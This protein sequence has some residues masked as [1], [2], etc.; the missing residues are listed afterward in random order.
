MLLGG[1]RRTTLIFALLLS[2]ALT[3]NAVLRPQLDW[4][5]LAYA[6]CVEELHGGDAHAIH[7][8][9][10]GAL[11]A[12]ASPEDA[13]RLRGEADCDPDTAHY[14]QRMADDP[15]AFHA[16]LPFYRGRV[17]YIALLALAGAI[18][19][20]ALDAALL[21]AL[22]SGLAFTAILL[23]WTTR[24]LPHGVALPA[25]LVGVWLAAVPQ[26][27][28]MSTPDMLAAALL[29]GGAY[30]LAETPRRA[31]G[32]A[33]LCLAVATRANHAILAAALVV[34]STPARPFG[35]RLP[36]RVVGTPLAALL[37]VGLL[38]TRARD[39]Y[40]WWTVFHHSF[41][42]YTAFPTVETPS[43]DVRAAVMRAL[44]SLP[45]FKALHPLVASLSGLTAIWLGARSRSWNSRPARLAAFVGLAVA[46]HF[47]LFPALWPRLMVAP[48][49][50][51]WIA[52]LKARSEHP[53]VFPDAGAV[54]SV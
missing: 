26:V 11:E 29:L 52:L 35:T 12:Q 28:S 27:M 47:A 21:I 49:A 46:L 22:I 33:L 4:D 20:G 8:A 7:A 6:G 40:P 31:L 37:V 24:F 5:V 16:Q 17:A 34:W 41:V 45:M 30:L 10:Y 13:R 39:T 15:A 18:G 25:T 50:L 9:A 32:V 43:R 51:L 44:H 38:C 53:R 42:E 1:A 36:F 14:R 48:W 19:F 2:A 3:V 54:T 23:R